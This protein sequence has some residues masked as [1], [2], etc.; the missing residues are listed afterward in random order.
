MRYASS[1]FWT[2]RY[3]MSPEIF[4]RAMS[5]SE[6]EILEG[7]LRRSPTRAKRSRRAIENAFVMWAASTL[8]FILCWKFLAWLTQILIH[9]DFGWSSPAAFWFLLL[10]LPACLMFAIGS[11]ANW[12][13]RWRDPRPLLQADMDGGR[14]REERFRFTEAKR[15]QEQEHGGLMYFLRTVDDKILVLFDHESQDLGL[16]G[17]SPLTSKFQPRTQLLMVRAPNTTYVI[18]QI[19]SGD[20][21]DAG[22]PLE[23][24]APPKKWPA[25]NSLL[26][27]PWDQL[28]ANFSSTEKR[29]LRLM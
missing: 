13:K 24:L 2:N 12:I 28:E 11:T 29:S 14:V 20:I 22:E 16:R 5:D 19:F 26:N 6:R 10:G 3:A 4:D 1:V 21:V 17:E 27:M 8:L 18:S 9:Y 25:Q 23:L 15:F 7:F